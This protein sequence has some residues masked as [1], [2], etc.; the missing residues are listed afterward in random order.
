MK[1]RTMKRFT[2][3]ALIFAS[4]QLRRQKAAKAKPAKV[5]TPTADEKPVDLNEIHRKFWARLAGKE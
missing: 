1:V 5:Q 4:A 3:D 2:C